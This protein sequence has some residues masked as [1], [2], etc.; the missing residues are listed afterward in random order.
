MGWWAENFSENLIGGFLT[1]RNERASY[2]IGFE[3][4]VS[5]LQNTGKCFSRK[6]SEV[7]EPFSPVEFTGN[8]YDASLIAGGQVTEWQNHEEYFQSNTYKQNMR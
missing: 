3:M 6:K 4:L 5:I 7:T 1:Q 8:P 2:A